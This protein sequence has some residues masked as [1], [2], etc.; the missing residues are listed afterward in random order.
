M[1]LRAD[2]LIRISDKNNNII[3]QWRVN[4]STEKEAEIVKEFFL[5]INNAY[6]TLD[7]DWSMSK[8]T[9]EK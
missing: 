2:W 1:N 3:K 4:D 9:E 7:E 6:N 5:T 8:I